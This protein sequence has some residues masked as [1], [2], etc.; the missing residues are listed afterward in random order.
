[1]NGVEVDPGNSGSHNNDTKEGGCTTTT[2]TT[3]GNGKK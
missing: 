2:T 1:V 3:M